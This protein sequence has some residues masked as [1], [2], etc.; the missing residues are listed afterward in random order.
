MHGGLPGAAPDHDEQETLCRPPSAPLGAPWPT[1]TQTRASGHMR[2]M[3]QGTRDSECQR[4][5][6][7]SAENSRWGASWEGGTGTAGSWSTTP[8]SSPWEPPWVPPQGTRSSSHGLSWVQ[9]GCLHLICMKSRRCQA[10]QKGDP[11]WAGRAAS[12]PALG[13]GQAQAP[14]RWR[15]LRREAEEFAR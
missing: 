4:T 11:T 8:R 6:L 15:W 2:S 10:E 14:A 5:V 1:S 12:P 9:E 13:P 3:W 7:R